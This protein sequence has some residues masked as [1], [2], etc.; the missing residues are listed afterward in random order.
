[1]TFTFR[2]LN[3][4]LYVYHCATAPVPMH[5]ANGMYGLIFVDPFEGLAPVDHEFYFMQ[6]EFYTAGANGEK[7][8]QPFSQEKAVREQP[9]YVVFNGAV[10]DTVGDKA[11]VVQ[12][13]ESVR[14]F[15]G[16]G[17]PNLTSSF[18]VIGEIFDR[19]YV[20][21]GTR[22]NEN[23]QT[24]LIPAGGSAVVEFVCEAPAML[25]LVDHSLFRVFNK[26][27][28]A[29]IRVTG[30]VNAPVYS[31]KQDLRDYDP[32]APAFILPAD[33]TI[34]PVL[35]EE[36]AAPIEPKTA[37]ERK[38]HGLAVYQRS[39]IACHGPTGTGMPAVFPPLAQSDFLHERADK[40]IGIVLA[41]LQ[42]AVKVNG[43]VYNNVMPAQ[44][45][46]DQEIASVLTY[47]HQ[48]WG[49]TG[50]EVT[51]EDVAGTRA[52]LAR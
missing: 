35:P 12:R 5:V 39:C 28:L 33:A 29:Q 15:V 6:S 49:N 27:A 36:P 51:V 14:L 23:V 10:G 40:G 3:P 25:N 44:P 7:G 17:G 24:T 26:G 16:N 2:A 32:S 11:P 48:S 1:V 37:A 43:Q 19:V 47:V 9:E 4:G 34:A 20:E 46:T 13:G 31:G 41:G 50:G 42:G 38:E 18:H 45:L 52:K 30:D 8:L 21:G 22:V